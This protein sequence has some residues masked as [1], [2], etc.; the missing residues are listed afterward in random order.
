MPTKKNLKTQ[1]EE[2]LKVEGYTLQNASGGYVAASRPTTGGYKDIILV[3]LKAQ[4]QSEHDLLD[5]IEETSSRYPSA[6]HT[7]LVPTRG[8]LSRDFRT[9]ASELK[10]KI[11]VPVQFFDAPFR[12]ES[13]PNATSAISSLRDS[14]PEYIPQ[15]YKS[16]N[17]KLG[18][19]LLAD[20]KNKYT[21]G[22]QYSNL[23]I[24][25]GPAGSGKSMFFRSLFTELY[26]HFIQKKRQQESFPRPIPLLPEYL[27]D[28]SSVR[29]RVLIE[30]FL[31]TDVAQ[32]VSLG[33]FEWMVG[34]GYSMCLFDGL[35]ELYAGDKDFFRLYIRFYNPTEHKSTVSD[36][37]KKFIVDSK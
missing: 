37:C 6:R 23:R 24:I 26:D 18:T 22:E 2:Y 4:K 14:V 32:P 17:T 35:D 33:S 27:R 36:L 21:T 20:L 19:D 31:R 1:V 29:T 16:K 13:A 7:I 11:R 15:P 3:W 30:D 8:G 5:K 34:N 25:V 12:V 10:I 28:D 9:R